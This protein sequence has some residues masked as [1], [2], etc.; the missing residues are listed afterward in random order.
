MHRTALHRS[1]ARQGGERQAGQGRSECGVL[2]TRTSEDADMRRR[3][4]SWE[5]PTTLT[6]HNGAVVTQTTKIAV[7]GCP[8]A[9]AAKVATAKRAAAARKAADAANARRS[10]KA[11]RRR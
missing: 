11:A 6:A 5:M 7:A 3:S 4:P 8:S 2:R 10:A 1:A 9:A